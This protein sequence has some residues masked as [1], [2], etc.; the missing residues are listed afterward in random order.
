MEYKLKLLITIILLVIIS[1]VSAQ[2]ERRGVTIYLGGFYKGDSLSIYANDIQVYNDTLSNLIFG[3]SSNMKVPVKW[4][5]FFTTRRVV[6]ITYI[7]HY[8][9]KKSTIKLNVKK[10]ET[11]LIEDYPKKDKILQ[12]LKFP[13]LKHDKKNFVSYTIAKRGKGMIFD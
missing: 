9:Q 3:T 2:V 7:N 11:L 10:Y 4:F 6:K 12:N 8:R 5:E 13:N 1:P